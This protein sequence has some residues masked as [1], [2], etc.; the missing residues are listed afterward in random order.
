MMSNN[1][2]GYAYLRILEIDQRKAI[3]CE[4][5]K[6][7]P[8]FESWIGIKKEKLIG[9]T[10]RSVFA[11]SWELTEELLNTFGKALMEGADCE[12]DFL[13]KP[14]NQWFRIRLVIEEKTYA[15]AFFS[16]I[17]SEIKLAQI[18]EQFL[19]KNLEEIGYQPIIDTALELSGARYGL[20]NLFDEKERVS[21]TV[22]TGGLQESWKKLASVLGFSILGKKWPYD[23][24]LEKKYGNH[25][26]PYV[27]PL[28]ELVQLSI[29]KPIIASLQR[30]FKIGDT[31]VS[32]IQKG[33]KILGNFTLFL[34][35]RQSMKNARLMEV[36]SRQVGLLISRSEAESRLQISE[37][38]LHRAETFT[39]VILDHLPVGIAAS[40]L[41]TGQLMRYMN[42]QFPRIYRTTRD[43]LNNIESFWEAV[44]EDPD[45]R[46]QIKKRVMEDCAS[47]DFERMQ[48]DDIPITRGNET[49]AFVTAK[50]IPIPEE[51]LMISMVADVTDRKRN[52]TALIEAKRKAEEAT[53]A[54]SRFLSNMSHEL[55]TPLNGIIGFA[56]LMKDTNLD[57]RQSEYLE[58]ILASSKALRDVV[59]NILDFSKIEAKKMELYEEVIEL[60][61]LCRSVE[62][63]VTF[64]AFQ[65]G[66]SVDLKIDPEIPK[67]LFI[68]GV[69]LSQVLLNLMG[70]AVKFTHHGHVCL[71]VDL[72]E[73]KESDARM[74][75]RFSV[76]D[77]GIGISD[78]LIERIFQS[79]EQADGSFT[80][81]YGGTGLGL[82]ISSEILRL[83][84]TSL[85]VTSHLG[86]GSVF[87]FNLPVRRCEKISQDISDQQ[88]REEK[89]P[90]SDIAKDHE[91]QWQVMVVEDDQ[92]NMMLAK[93]LIRKTLPNAKLIEAFN[94]FEALSQ[95][96]KQKLD[97]VFMDLHMP[98]MDG[99]NSTREIRKLE[100]DRP[101]RVPII[102]LTAA[103]EEG[104]REACMACGMD[105]FLT[106]PVQLDAFQEA[107]RKWIPDRT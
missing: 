41:H 25:T 79:F 58:F 81:L 26:V 56:E 24:A 37:R 78:Q 38:S 63:M 1:S 85:Q 21:V 7:N 77:T 75:L 60:E 86:K 94:G 67:T 34:P 98:V 101:S 11:E 91:N 57:A 83:M 2:I 88:K 15:H 53:Q 95:F 13:F 32:V 97:M 52:E 100:K 102:A 19:E 92:F 68:D 6:V 107:I 3:D 76:E 39:K 65:K 23:T 44:Y 30:I 48:W 45:F 51:D 103:A 69:R 106:K 87:S 72:L 35:A 18:S 10:L 99:F 55:R 16:N 20:F 59:G 49:I 14:K 43:R 61:A 82:T 40:S 89:P 104:N 17:T 22:A 46:A 5:L 29:P 84:D 9:S 54:K 12:A 96:E 93:T 62:R 42:D 36:Y 33:G 73:K 74:T 80:R 4:F 71:S 64:Q 90:V 70:N 8:E 50:N 31:V 27:I 47:G 28:H 66:I 105:D